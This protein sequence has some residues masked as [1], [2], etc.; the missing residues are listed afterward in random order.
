MLLP[1]FLRY[2]NE[3]SD[4]S[5]TVA[6]LLPTQWSH[7]RQHIA[8]RCTGVSGVRTQHHRGLP[9]YFGGSSPDL[10]GDV[11][12]PQHLVEPRPG[13]RAGT[14]T[15]G[16][17]RSGSR[18]S[19]GPAII[20]GRLSWACWGGNALAAIATS[21]CCSSR[22]SWS[23]FQPRRP[24]GTAARPNAQSAARHAAEHAGLVIALTWEP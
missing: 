4:Q 19:S 12:L 20:C 13:P 8:F 24:P 18:R 6:A 21:R 23:R 1:L 3:V 22:L 17:C 9:F 11:H 16:S 10:G 15:S 5:Y 2:R 14:S 7:G